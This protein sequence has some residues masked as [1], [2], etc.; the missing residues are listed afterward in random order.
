[1]TQQPYTEADLRAEAARQHADLAK[2][3][4]EGC[5]GDGMER[6]RVPSVETEKD[7]SART[8]AELLDPEGDDTDEF[9]AAQQEIHALITSAAD[10]STWAIQLGAAGLTPHP[11]MGWYCTTSGWDT[12]VQIATHPDLRPDLVAEIQTAVRAAV[13]NVMAS[14]GCTVTHAE[15]PT[16]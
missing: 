13:D 15:E 3:S 5:V 11:A 9:R 8:W 1:M 14:T 12:A 4:D 10:V 2:N 6:G 7:G 16:R